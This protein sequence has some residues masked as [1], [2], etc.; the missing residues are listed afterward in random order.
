MTR[1]ATGLHAIRALQELLETSLVF[2][3]VIVSDDVRKLN[4]QHFRCQ[5]YLLYCLFRFNVS[6]TPIRSRLYPFL[7][8]WFVLIRAVSNRYCMR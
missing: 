8:D 2:D 1:V 3:S 7:C 5:E 6:S 4:F